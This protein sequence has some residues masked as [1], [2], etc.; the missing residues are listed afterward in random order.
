MLRLDFISVNKCN[1]AHNLN[2]IAGKQ[3]DTKTSSDQQFLLLLSSGQI[4]TQLVT[5]LHHL[6]GADRSWQEV[7]GVSQIWTRQRVVLRGRPVSHCSWTGMA[8]WQ[9]LIIYRDCTEVSLNIIFWYKPKC[10]NYFDW[11]PLLPLIAFIFLHREG[12]FEPLNFSETYICD[13]DIW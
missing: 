5:F 8:A 6:A 11:P 12:N 1:A 7:G 2:C 10:D 4:T 13:S 3:V 9:L